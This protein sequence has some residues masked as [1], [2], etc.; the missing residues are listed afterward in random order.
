LVLLQTIHRFIRHLYTMPLVRIQHS[1]SYGHSVFL[2][3]IIGPLFFFYYSINR[4]TVLYLFNL[5]VLKRYCLK[6]SSPYTLCEVMGSQTQICSFLKHKPNVGSTLIFHLLP[7]EVSLARRVYNSLQ[8]SMNCDWCS[9]SQAYY[10]TDH[11]FSLE[12]L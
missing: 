11:Y 12:W 1:L 10:N 6:K 7:S 3:W 5:G 9:L 4:K 8:T 2:Y